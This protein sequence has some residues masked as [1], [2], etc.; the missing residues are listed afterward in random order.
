LWIGSYFG[1]TLNECVPTADWVRKKK[2]KKKQSQG[3]REV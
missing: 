3:K 1:L 2:K